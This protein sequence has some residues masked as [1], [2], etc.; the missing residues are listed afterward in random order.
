M[1]RITLES[2]CVTFPLVRSGPGPKAL[3]LPLLLPQPS[4]SFHSSPHREPQHDLVV[5]IPGLI[6]LVILLK[7]AVVCLLFT[8]FIKYKDC[9]CEWHTS[10]SLLFVRLIH[11]CAYPCSSL[12]S[13]DVQY[14]TVKGFY[15]LSVCIIII[16]NTIL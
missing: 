15:N 3:Q 13:S 5:I 14:S 16:T 11:V 10:L 1:S 8:N 7:G 6:F 9:F 12:T 2:T 4:S